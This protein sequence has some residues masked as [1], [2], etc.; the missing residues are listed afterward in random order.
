RR[1]FLA[2]PAFASLLPAQ[3]SA[4]YRS[5]SPFDVGNRSQLFIDGVLAA[6]SKRIAYTLHTAQKHPSNPLMKADRPWE[7]WRLEIYGNVIYDEDEKIFKMWYLGEAPGYFAPSPGGPSADN[8]TL[9]ATSTDGIRWEKP[10]VGTLHS[11][12]SSAHNAVVFATHLASVVKDKR[13]PDSSRRY[14]MTCYVHDPKEARGYQ[15]LTSPD[16]LRW[17]RLSSKPICRGSD[18]ITSYWDEA[19]GMYVALAKIGTQVRG[20]NRRVFYL[21]TSTDFVHWT[22]PELVW[23]PDLRDDAGSLRRIEAARRLLDVPDDPA[24]MRTE[25]YGFGFYPQESCVLAFPWMFTIN[26]RARYGN[27][28]G[29][30]EL[31]LGVSRDLRHWARPFRTPC[32]QL[33]APGE[34]DE[35]LMVTVSQ[36]LRVK[37][38]VWLYYGGSKYTH[39]TPVLYR[40]QG[41]GRGTKYTGSIGLASWKLDRFV[42]AD[43]PAEGGTLRTVP[44]T[45]T[46]TKLELNA[47]TSGNGRVAVTILDAAGKPLPGFEMSQ[48]V[49]GDVI[50]Q[51]VKW[52]GGKSVASLASRPVCL[53][54][55]VQN[56]QLFSFAFR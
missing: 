11:P 25:F 49:R 28:E 48:P 56:A 5:E 52:P 24:Q 51:E 2:T 42:S 36:A 12:Q 23:S 7:G 35:G 32:V 39:G 34:W 40:D 43:G 4:L 29:P 1:T 19:R 21:L 14:K 30:F 15:T 8:S 22:E 26:A 45:F 10:N 46:G 17:S 31:Q 41:T 27:Q 16:G 50:R 9:Y 54:F 33:G 6:E 53:Q 37:D 13:D 44:V 20:H 55:L 47:K 3:P 18:V 38:E